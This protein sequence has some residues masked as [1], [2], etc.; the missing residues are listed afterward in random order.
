MKIKAPVEKAV[1]ARD[2]SK[3]TKE[4]TAV[5]RRTNTN[6]GRMS[7]NGKNTKPDKT[8]LYIG[9]GV[10]V[11]FFLMIIIAAAS[12]SSESNPA[13]KYVA[14]KEAKYSLPVADRMKIYAAYSKAFDEIE[15][16]GQKEINSLGPESSR[17]KGP[18]IRDNVL[19]EQQNMRVELT[20]KFK[21]S[22][23]GLTSTYFK[24]I[25]DE[26]I[27]KGWPSN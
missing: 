15:A 8:K 2:R 11:F 3:G 14:E 13:S 7:K 26:G 20:A 25:V 17:D 24:K 27:D 1:G 21:K 9:I 23:D 5:G 19:R 6:A 12:S 16:K 22:Y 18:Q 10:G 4:K